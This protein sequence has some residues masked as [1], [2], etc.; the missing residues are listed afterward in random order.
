MIVDD[1]PENL[2]VLGEMLRQENWAV[3]AFASGAA[4]LAATAF[5]E[6]PDLVLL[7]IRMPGLDGYEVC[8]RFKANERLRA[9]PI[10]FLSASTATA[11]KVQAFAVGG[12]DYVSKP[13]AAIEVLARAHTHIQ[14]SRQAA[15][16][17]REGAARLRAVTDSAHDAILMMDPQGFI[18][19][20]NPA[21]ER[22]LGY[23]SSEV[24]GQDLHQ[25]MAPSRY[26][27]AHQAAF[28][29]F[30]RTGQGGVISGTRELA[31]RRKDGQEIAVEI[32]FSALLL[33]DG[34]HAVGIVRDITARK[35]VEEELRE[36]NRQLTAAAARTNELAAHAARASA[37]KGEFLAN[38]S[39]EIR[40]PL[41][42]VIGMTGLLLDTALD[43]EQRHYAETV[44]C[45][46]EALLGLINDILD[47]SKIEAGKLDLEILDFDLP[48]LLDDFA[49]S[50]ALRAHEKGLE[51]LC[52]VDPAVPAR[53]RG[54]PGRLRQILTN[55]AGNAVKFTSA[56][57]VTIRVALAEEAGSDVLLR[58]SVRDTGIGIAA[59]KRGL[60]FS[61]FSQVDA[62]IT[63]Q[64]G[65][66]GLGLAISKQLAE[67]MGGQV[68]VESVEGQ[69]SEFWFT[70]RLGRQT[71]KAAVEDRPA[72]DLHGVRA[73][74]VDDNATGRDLLTIRLAAWGLRPV[75]VPDG[76]T[77]L[78]ALAQ[79][80]AQR[81]P[82]R[83]ALI[84]MQM[85]GMDGETLGRII[86]SD[87]RLAD[88]RM[89]LLTSLGTRG[90][91]RRLQ[92]IGFA[93]YATKPIRHE[94]LRAMLSL[95]L[96]KQSEAAPAPIVTR[97]TTYEAGNRL[98]GR[99]ARILL[100]EDNLVNQRVVLGML[101][102]M[103]LQ[104]DVVANGAEALHALETLPYDLV[105]M[106]VQMP[107]LDGIGA[108]RRIRQPD[109]AVRNHGIPI[110]ALTANAMQG[111][112]ARFLAAGMND[113]VAKPVSRQALAEALERWLPPAP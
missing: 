110:I 42:G 84:D 10:I 70:V 113:H 3:R 67:L 30:A 16:A 1:E 43:A 41:N 68:G 85:P 6:V 24:L 100:A 21:T 46:G 107:E 15:E 94:E 105:L 60:L 7:D 109:S 39:H 51:L 82:F 19:Y 9:I 14:L 65:G 11:D 91:A 48:S 64:Y 32:S 53:L 45:S 112:R 77:A 69:G 75:A 40:T 88:T 72:A 38:M 17:L 93:A 29:S 108:T 25:L 56:G 12:V 61:K 102:K 5:D 89:L 98:A 27:A 103:G 57:E 36:T 71:G 37:A 33:G 47:F 13:F 76:P 99:P 22:I 31:A 111:D 95:A 101:K 97:H 73:L 44:R 63:R 35:Q 74:V 26:H 104:A 18:T 55:L 90:D 87:A 81:D 92:E 4:A 66:S 28:P 49:A 80:L 2:N 83:L 96:R 78:W 58:F 34:W 86:R 54:D 62:S 59:E 20:S 23:S 50:L 79:A 8:R 106:D 52:A